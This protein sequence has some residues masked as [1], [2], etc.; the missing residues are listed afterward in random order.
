M[1]KVALMLVLSLVVMGSAA[2]ASCESN[3]IA[4]GV[5]KVTKAP[6]DMMRGANEHVVEPVSDVN[7]GIIDFTDHV[8]AGAVSVGLNLGQPVE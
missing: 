8:R 3:G 5:E 2:P 4:M 6:F 1:S 7:Y